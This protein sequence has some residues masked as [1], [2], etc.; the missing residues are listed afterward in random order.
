MAV[1]LPGP[2]FSSCNNTDCSHKLLSFN[3]PQNNNAMD[4]NEDILGE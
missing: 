2:S 4:L 1:Y 3:V